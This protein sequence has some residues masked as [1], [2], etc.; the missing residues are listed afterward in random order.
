MSIWIHTLNI[1]DECVLNNSAIVKEMIKIKLSELLF[2]SQM[3]TSKNEAR[4][5]IEQGGV[6]INSEKVTA[7]DEIKIEKMRRRTNIIIKSKLA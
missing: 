3:V 4:R 1:K 7:D 2:V 6:K 5:L